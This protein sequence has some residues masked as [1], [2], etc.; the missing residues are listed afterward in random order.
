MV[1]HLTQHLN[2][3]LNKARLHYYAANESEYIGV[4]IL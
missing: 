2:T 4:F 1:F 3:P